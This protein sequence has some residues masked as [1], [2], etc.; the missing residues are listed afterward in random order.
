MAADG[1][2]VFGRLR[3]WRRDG[4]IRELG[5]AIGGKKELL[6]RWQE[7]LEKQHRQEQVAM[8]RAHGLEAR[9]IEE[10]G[11]AAYRR[12][13]E[14]SEERAE[15]AVRAGRWRERDD[16]YSYGASDAE[17]RVAWLASEE[18]LEQ[19]REVEG[20]AAYQE[21]KRARDK[22]W[23]PRPHS[24]RPSLDQLRH[25]GPERDIGFER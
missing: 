2:G 21:R 3:R 25:R 22:A 24:P 23:Q 19:V 6:R 18:R 17:R 7:E 10:A 20:E 11:G 16:P 8:G 12:R 4:R 1:R 13:M 5:A 15:K 14:G 9:A